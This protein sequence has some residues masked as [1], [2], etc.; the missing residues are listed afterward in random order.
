MFLSKEGRQSA[1]IMGH[2]L[3]FPLYDGDCSPTAR[4]LLAVGDV[5]GAIAEWRRLAD[6]GSGRARCVLAY[7]A[8]KGASPSR[9]GRRQPLVN[10]WASHPEQDLCR[11]RPS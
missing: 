8:L 1:R 4:N 9:K 6:L 10:T 2:V 3:N 5:D 7:L 11:R